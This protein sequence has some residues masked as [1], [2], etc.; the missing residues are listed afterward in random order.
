MDQESIVYGLIRD[1]AYGSVRER[2]LRQEHNHRI[3]DSLPA[4]DGWPFLCRDMFGVSGFDETSGTYQTQVIHFGASY[5]AVEYEWEQWMSKFEA[6]LQQMY[7]VGAKVH[8][9]TELSGVHTFVWETEKA[10]HEPNDP[11][12]VRCEWER[13]GGL[14]VRR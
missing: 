1:I 11:L 5:R 13:E 3:I 9:E 7:W 2:R 12:M 10:F 14:G 4:A 6:V 8:L